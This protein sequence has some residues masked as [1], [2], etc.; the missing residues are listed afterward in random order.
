MIL[1]C[2]IQFLSKLSLVPFWF[3]SFPIH[4]DITSTAFP[5]RALSLAP[6]W[7]ALPPP[8]KERWWK[9]VASPPHGV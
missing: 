2:L 4:P 8:H 3:V 1:S 9:W 6:P 7:T 5:A